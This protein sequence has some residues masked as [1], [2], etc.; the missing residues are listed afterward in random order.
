MNTDATN[1]ANPWLQIAHLG[2]E[3]AALHE[4]HM[5]TAAEIDGIL[6]QQAERREEL[7]SLEKRM[8]EVKEE[9][10]GLDS[11][12]VARKLS[13][14]QIGEEMR[15]NS[16]RLA[17]LQR[18]VSGA[19]EA[20]QGGDGLREG[21]DGRGEGGGI[22]GAGVTP[23]EGRGASAEV[24]PTGQQ[25]EVGVK[26]EEEEDSFEDILGTGNTYNRQSSLMDNSGTTSSRESALSDSATMPSNSSR[27]PSQPRPEA[28][29]LPGPKARQPFPDGKPRPPKR[30]AYL[31]SFSPYAAAAIE[32]GHYGPRHL[33][34]ETAP[35]SPR[36][37]TTARRTNALNAASPPVTPTST[38][39]RT[40]QDSTLFTGG[41][42]DTALLASM[43]ARIE[44]TSARSQRLQDPGR[45][46]VPFGVNERD[47]FRPQADGEGGDGGKKKSKRRKIE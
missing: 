33:R 3:N 26:G 34:P 46:R 32:A 37:P 9:L 24:V 22:G 43:Q 25:G 10:R 35:A 12:L 1:T 29:S 30:A 42:A 4:Q 21:E 45:D 15:V 20:G 14:G 28:R 23:V 11:R 31:S 7:S 47:L 40:R 19:G 41:A 13:A 2:N 27:R 5:E 44:T 36:A 38:S 8:E 6:V 39:Q 18:R 17:E 16:E